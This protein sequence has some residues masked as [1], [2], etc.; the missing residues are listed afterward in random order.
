MVG[1][2]MSE[3][4]KTRVEHEVDTRSAALGVWLYRRTHG[5]ITRPWRRRAIVLTTRGRRSGRPRTVLVQVFQ[6]GP[7]LFVVAA[8]SGLPRPPGWYFN[9]RSEPHAVGELEGHRLRIRAELLPESET[10]DRWQ[11]VLALAP[12]YERYTRRMGRVPPIFHLVTE[13]QETEEHR[14]V[15]IRS[16]VRRFATMRNLAAAV[17]VLA[18]VGGFVHGMGEVLQG[19]GSPSGVVFDSWT[20]GRIATNLG[21]EPAMT[22]VPDL[23]TTGLL[24]IGVSA[25]VTLW[26]TLFLDR[27]FGGTGLAFL[28]A[29]LMLVGGGFGP[30]VLGLLAALV[31]SGSHRGRHRS[32]RWVH[33]RLGRVLN[34]MWPPLF[35]LCLADAVF[36]VFGSV[37]A[38]VVLNLD[39][40]AAF[41][42][43]LFLAVLAMP[44][45]TIAGIAHDIVV[46]DGQARIGP[47]T[48]GADRVESSR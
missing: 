21:G 46:G 42:Y 16:T 7:D 34:A 26:A 37:V 47:W 5:R 13:Q 48:P 39:I 4:L 12:D 35:W 38:G 18:G 6:D 8:N 19:S 2:V 17:G 33:S 43:A 27:R 11:W 3:K 36:L 22:V 14:T 25:A 28:S 45:T 31:A 40:S 20:Q 1:P 29:L 9:L 15:G 41:V 30:P 24:T 32:H 23:L 44:V 10:T